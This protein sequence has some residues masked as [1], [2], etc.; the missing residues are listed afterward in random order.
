MQALQKTGWKV[1]GPGGAAELLGLST[2]TL[3]FRM[4]R[5]GIKRPPKNR[6]Q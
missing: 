2:S 5:M 6:P 1:Y 4:K 3:A